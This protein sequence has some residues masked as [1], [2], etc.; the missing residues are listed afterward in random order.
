MSDIPARRWLH[1][2]VLSVLVA[3]AIYVF[4]VL[5]PVGQALENGALRGADQLSVSEVNDANKNLNQ[6]T[7]YSLAVSV[8]VVALIG[9]LRRRWELAV[10]AVGVIVA[11]Q[12]VTQ[13]LKRFV[14]PR[15]PLV[16]VSGHYAAN[17]LPSGHT[18]IAMTVLFA[19]LIVVP[20]RWRGVAMF[21]AMSWAVGIGEYTVVAK[22]HRVS[23]TLAADAI[24][25]A[26]GCLASWWLARRGLVRHH[27][28]RSR[29]LR[30]LFVLLTVAFTLLVLGLGVVFLWSTLS[31]EGLDATLR[32]NTWLLYLSGSLFASVGSAVAALVFL[33]TWRRLEIPSFRSTRRD[34]R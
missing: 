4:A 33:A 10:A 32:D 20:Y 8:V 17:S 6:I 13:S 23:D 3:V 7:V 9:L 21:F 26:L 19:A 18:T 22:W 24:A 5:T 29:T 11:G 28:G 25:L 31:R 2:A 15:P 1:V 12:V 30:V 16:Q 34:R 14:L 27:D